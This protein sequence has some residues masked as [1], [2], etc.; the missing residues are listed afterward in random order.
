ML[1][2]M[3]TS[4]VPTRAE[5]S[6]VA[7]AVYEG[8]DAVML[9]AESASGRY[10]V[11]AVAMM[12]RIVARVESDDAYR[13]EL[14]AS[15]CEGGATTADA[16]ASALR[17]V[18]KSIEPAAT[19]TYTASGFSSLRAARERPTAPVLGLTPSLAT[20]RRLALVW[21]I[22]AVASADVAD[23][24]GMIARACDTAVREGFAKPGDD[25][26]VVAGL[27]FGRSG[28]TNLLHVARIAAR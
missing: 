7:T 12:E 5:V 13:A 1:E 11:E 6:D 26:V 24:D 27:P 16:L 19:V 22:H 15:Q 3:V 17:C 18:A 25:I 23:V 8:V 2:S 20:A 28:T 21:G 10:P 4:P 9:S 14:E